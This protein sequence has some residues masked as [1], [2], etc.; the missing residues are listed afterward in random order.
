[1]RPALILLLA[2]GAAACGR[3]GVGDALRV[4]PDGTAILNDTSDAQLIVDA[5]GCQSV[6]PASG[7][8]AE[9]V[10]DADGNQVCA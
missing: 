1:M 3:G 9:P 2:L 10:T 5:R 4:L 8:P 7:G 6:V